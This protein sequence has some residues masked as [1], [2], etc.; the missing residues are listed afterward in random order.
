MLSQEKKRLAK[1]IGSAELRDIIIGDG[2]GEVSLRKLRMTMMRLPRRYQP[3]D[4]NALDKRL[5]ALNAP[6][7]DAQ[8]RHPQEHAPAE[9]PVPLQPRPVALSRP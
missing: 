7:P 4:V 6:P 1:V 5:K 2:E 9:G 8:G 3:K